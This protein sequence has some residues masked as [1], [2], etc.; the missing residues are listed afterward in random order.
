[1]K[2]YA[3][4]PYFDDFDETK[5]FHQIMFKPGFAVQA[6]ELSQLQTILRNQIEK[7]GNHIFK[8]GSVVIPGNAFADLDTPCI[9]LQPTY[10]GNN[11][12]LENFEGK[13]IVGTVTGVKAIVKK[14]VA[15]TTTDPVTFYISYTTG[16][17]NN[18]NIFDANEELYVES[19]VAIRAITLA[20]NH[21]GVGSLAFINT[22]VFYIRGTFVHIDA[23]SVVI[24]KYTSTPSCHVLLKI[25]ESIVTEITDSTLLDPAQGSYNYAAPGA[26]RVKIGLTLTSLPLGSAITEDYVE[27]MRYNQGVLE[28]HAKYPSYSEL[29]KSLARRTF[30]E[31]GNYLV[32]GFAHTIREHLKTQYN[33]GVYL[34]GNRD[35]FVVEVQPG[36]GYIDGLEVE[37][38][39]KKTIELDKARTTDHVK[40]KDV[41]IQNAYGRYIYVSG[42]KSLP[43][44]STRQVVD[45]YND[46]DRDNTSATKVGTV[47]VLAI[48]YHS[49]DAAT[50]SAIYKLFIDELALNSNITLEDVGGIRFDTTGAMSVIQRFSVPNPSVDFTVNEVI[51]SG[52]GTKAATVLSFS[53]ATGDLYVYKHDHTK[54][55]PAVGDLITGVTSTAT[56]TIRSN[57]N[58]GTVNNGSAPI[59]TIPTIAIKSLKNIT[60]N[61][62]DI[63]YTVW[64]R[65]VITTNASGYGTTTVTDGTIVSPEVGNLVAA[66][67]AGIVSVDKFS[68]S[69]G[70]TQL[71][72]TGG[73]VSTAVVAFVQAEKTGAQPKVK[74]LTSR[75]LT[76]IAPATT[77]QLDKADIY[78]VVLIS[79][80]DGNDV[81]DSY[82]LNNGQT[83]YY[84]GLGSL[85]LVKALPT[86]NLS[87]TF[88]YFAHSGSGDYFCVDSYATLGSDYISKATKY[89]SKSTSQV[90]N[91]ATCI[92][93]RPTVG[94]TGQFDTGDASLINLPVINTF[95]STSVQYYVPRIDVVYLNKDKT[96]NVVRGVP[97]DIPARPV[98]PESSVEIAV[99]FIPAYTVALSDILSRSLKN[100]R[101]TM[102]DIKKLENRVANVEYYS[103]LNSLETS[104]ISYDVVDPTTGLNRF[105]TGYLADNFENASTVCDFFNRDNRCSFFNQSLSSAIEDHSANIALLDSSANYQLTGNQLTLPYTETPL[106]SQTTST[107]VTNLNPFM[108]FSWEGL[109]TIDPPFD[110]WIETQDLPTIYVTKEE[111]I[112]IQIPRSSPPPS[113]P[114]VV[115]PPVV[116]D[117]PVP[118]PTPA[119]V[120]APTPAPPPPPPAPVPA[121][122]PTRTVTA[123]ARDLGLVDPSLE[124]SAAWNDTVTFTVPESVFNQTYANLDPRSQDPSFFVNNDWASSSVWT[125]AIQAIN[126]AFNS[127]ISASSSTGTVNTSGSRF[128]SDQITQFWQDRT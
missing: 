71:V 45:L 29:E 43:N 26:D 84:Y 50:E 90:F 58:I 10:N 81:T 23:Q 68:L 1:M 93:F 48:D 61:Q 113:P 37:V 35:K 116:W 111:T 94:S 92:D 118:A 89:V 55:I 11:L 96:I 117:R 22:G 105:K 39:A 53:R 88:E 64:K 107:R 123:W 12:I 52:S 65:L 128:T 38:I 18:E 77:I 34:D 3:V 110:T 126:T 122:E 74:T 62:Y 78:K 86:S 51:T 100:Y 99:I 112:E 114:P 57:E 119:P 59:F 106:I 16:G 103:T 8:H 25:D 87:I 47:R 30:D 69:G 102:G 109:M 27:I 91:L 17:T 83:D 20:S 28:E 31:S 33:N 104:L 41:T 56:G 98:S 73:P 115:D 72:L 40:D 95:N 4:S 80:A 49:G 101:Y 19:N 70:G 76:N 82:R 21:T 13:I 42:L 14:A 67:S 124:N 44:F 5:N 6:R 127:A 75:T 36:K 121:P 60:T 120:P 108:V 7:F 2:T 46:N 125:G 9:K 66:S 24:S 85:E 54:S 97:K 32:S 79:D 63:A 15:A